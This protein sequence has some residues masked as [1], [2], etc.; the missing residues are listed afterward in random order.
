MSSSVK[1]RELDVFVFKGE[2]GEMSVDDV[3]GWG[4]HL[5]TCSWLDSVG[6]WLRQM[7]LNSSNR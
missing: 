4:R 1:V 5:V 7:M 2:I 3:A 6:H